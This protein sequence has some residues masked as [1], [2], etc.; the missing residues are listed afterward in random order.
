MGAD[1]EDTGRV[2][3]F[4]RDLFGWEFSQP[5]GDYPAGYLMSTDLQVFAGLRP[6]EDRHGF[7]PSFEVS[8]VAAAVA[9][10]R[11]LGGIAS[12]PEDKPHGRVS[13]CEYAGLTFYVG[14]PPG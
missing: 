14:Q 5:P 12:D 8:D 2:A 9:R 10:V 1:V 6:S 4:F 13:L 11:Q 3:E 7:A